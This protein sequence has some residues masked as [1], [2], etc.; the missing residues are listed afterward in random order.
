MLCNARAGRRWIGIPEAGQIGGENRAA[1]ACDR[2]EAREN[3]P[4]VGACMQA[5]K[6]RGLLEA[7]AGRDRV[8][9]MQLAVAAL[10]IAA[11]DA[12]PGCGRRA[13]GVGFGM[14]TG[15]IVPQRPFGFKL[16]V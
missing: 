10:E 2:Q 6:W 13:G 7:A 5:Q 11:T 4:G 16:F 1:D 3:A 14:V 8:V 15:S 12:R 9:D